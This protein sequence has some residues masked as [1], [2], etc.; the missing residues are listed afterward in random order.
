MSEAIAAA[1]EVKADP[2]YKEVRPQE[3][4]RESKEGKVPVMEI[5]GPTLQGEGA[6][7]GVKTLFIRMGGC[8]YRCQKCDSMHAVI[9][10]S[11]NQNAD[12]IT[13]TEAAARVI[14]LARSSHTDWVTIS[15]GNPAMWD[16]SAMVDLLQDEGLKLALETQGTIWRDWVALCDQVTISPKAPGMGERYE[17]EV[18]VKFLDELRHQKALHLTQ[19]ISVKIV[20]FSALDLDFVAT[21]IN[22]VLDMIDFPKEWR[23]LSLGNDLPPVLN[24]DTLQLEDPPEL[25]D[26]EENMAEN[27]ATHLLAEFS[28]LLEDYLIDHRLSCWKFLPQLHVLIWHNKSRV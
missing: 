18:F 22:P 23:Y 3:K 10:L 21:A 15:G 28:I 24:A 27:L 8:D 16:L 17:Q 6:M 7:I 4:E 1:A 11:V 25:E 20:V 26:L 2:N 13:P 9:P 14:E 12:W 5:F 19:T